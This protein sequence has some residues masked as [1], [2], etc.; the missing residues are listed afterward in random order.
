MIK[1]VFKKIKRKFV[2]II[3]PN[4][5]H[6]RGCPYLFARY[7]YWKMTKKFLSYT[8]PK[9][10]SEKLFWYNRYWQDPLIVQCS[11]KVAVREYVKKCGLESILNNF[12]ATYEKASDID[13][14]ALP[15]TFV[16]KTNNNGASWYIVL[17]EDKSKLD[18][19]ATRKMMHQ[20]LHTS[21][22][23]LVC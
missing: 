3:M 4:L 9:S 7:Y 17:C 11:D 12:Y 20:A 22:P 19:E 21:P 13:F 14:E 10:I 18:F 5:P 23:P 8:F 16:L 15:D 2:K 1:N 6:H